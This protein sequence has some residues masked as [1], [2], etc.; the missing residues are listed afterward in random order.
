MHSTSRRTFVHLNYLHSLRTQNACAYFIPM[1]TWYYGPALNVP[2]SAKQR[3][4]CHAM[5][6]AVHLQNICS[7][8]SRLCVPTT[9]R[10]KTW[11]NLC[12]GATWTRTDTLSARTKESRM[13]VG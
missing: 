5:Q 8:T 13:F 3:E 9:F 4:G 1:L 6:T 7:D 12:H 11:R 2:T 10:L